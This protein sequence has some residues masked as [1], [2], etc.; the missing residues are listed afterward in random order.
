MTT[1]L[2]SS[3][4]RVSLEGSTYSIDKLRSFVMY[5]YFR[6]Q[7]LGTVGCTLW[8]IQPFPTTQPGHGG[9]IVA[10]LW[11]SLPMVTLPLQI[12]ILLRRSIGFLRWTGFIPHQDTRT[13][14]LVCLISDQN[15][16]TATLLYRMLRSN[17]MY[18][19][20]L[21][22]YSASGSSTSSR[23]LPWNNYR[24]VFRCISQAGVVLIVTGTLAG[25]NSVTSPRYLSLPAL[26]TP[27]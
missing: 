12:P 17:R 21:Q 1:S 25:G 6:T 15:T 22:P 24:R 5:P 27:D 26:T 7:V 11:R 20:Q 2:W 23:R 14:T 16:N 3:S 8:L 10:R 13:A 9:K 19:R 4:G 18:S